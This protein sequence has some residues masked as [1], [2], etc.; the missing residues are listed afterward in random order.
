MPGSVHAA[1]AAH[2]RGAKL[3]QGLLGMIVLAASA[4][5]AHRLLFFE[6]PL[7][8]PV[9]WS[10][11]QVSGFVLQPV[12]QRP[13]VADRQFARGQSVS[14]IANSIEEGVRRFRLDV[15]VV[16]SRE[17][18][19]LDV[20]QMT[21][22]QEQLTLQDAQTRQSDAPLLRQWRVGSMSGRF[23]AQTCVVR[24]SAAAVERN[25]LVSLLDAQRKRSPWETARQIAGLRDNIRWECA[26][27]TVTSMEPDPNPAAAEQMLVH[28]L[29]PIQRVYDLSQ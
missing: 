16:H 12:A 20:S 17:S 22:G 21:Q 6:T 24:S 9:D 25:A 28:V 29:G 14:A 3:Q 13:A 1:N 4:A 7:P 8:A 15:R 11:L 19:T 26:L 2:A 27:V 10:Q 18:E 5:L 23:A